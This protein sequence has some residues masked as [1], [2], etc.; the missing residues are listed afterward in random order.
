MNPA[1]INSVLKDFMDMR[2]N[3]HK[4]TTQPMTKKEERAKALKGKTNPSV[5]STDTPIE[6]TLARIIEA[7]PKRKEVET[8]LQA[9][10][11]KLTKEKM[12]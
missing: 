6:I 1:N 12:K 2:K 5:L 11:D 4:D 7:K 10:C 3:L 9:E 8:F